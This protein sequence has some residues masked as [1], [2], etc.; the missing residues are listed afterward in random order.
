MRGNSRAARARRKGW[1]WAQ[2]V[3][4]VSCSGGVSGG[5]V[6]AGRSAACGA[7]RRA[8][9]RMWTATKTRWGAI[10]WM[11]SIARAAS[12]MRRKWPRGIAAHCAQG[13]WGRSLILAVR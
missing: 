13:G 12:S 2:A 8:V 9:K 11:A 5:R 1:A 10:K 4:A 3:M 6:G 7:L